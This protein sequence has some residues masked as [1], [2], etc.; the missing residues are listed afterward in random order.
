MSR[1]FWKFFIF[2]LV[3]QLTTVIGVGVAIWA[4]HQHETLPST[5]LEISPPAQS[6]IEAAAATLQ[7][8]G[9]KSLKLLLQSRQNRHMPQ[10]FVVDEHGQELMQRVYTKASF[11]SASK[12]AKITKFQRYAKY[13]K[14]ND[15]QIFLLF[16]PYIEHSDGDI[17]INLA[18]PVGEEHD[19]SL[20]HGAPLRFPL[21]PLIGGSL[22]SL[23]FAALLAW[24]FSK[25][26]NKL[27]AAFI[28]ASN[29]KLD[30]RVAHSMSG[31]RDELSDL[32][33]D[34]DAMASRLSSLLRG[35][36]R[37]LHHVSHELRSP[38]ARMQMALGLVKQ[39]PERMAEFLVRVELE[40]N[41]IDK[42]VDELLELSRLESG[43][44]Q[45]K[46]E[47]LDLNKLIHNIA[48]DAQ[49][50]AMEKNIKLQL[51]IDGK[52]ELEGHPELLYRAIEN[53]IRNAI[54]YGPDGGEVKVTC[55]HNYS[56]KSLHIIVS[57]QGAGVEESELEDIFKPFVR[58]HAGSQTTGHG[59][60]LAITKQVIDAHDGRVSA[61]N[62]KPNGFC[63][64]MVLPC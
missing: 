63:V 5:G 48:E 40:T 14:L 16:V 30:L 50:E 8:G 54:K 19:R 35:Q 9:I 37:L 31:R 49:F 1:L 15:R 38:L 13:I 55:F 29:G 62:L 27:R 4:Q 12:L 10:V 46:K 42:L 57:D 47:N 6:D 53:V 61:R 2:F 22:V 18:P 39:R 33:R 20:S 36:T 59:I 3:A 41:R 56:E 43:V 23:I 24:Y 45:V 26:I 17:H 25:P 60:G 34:F 64:E 28:Q 11:D 52:C 7:Y 21:A 51:E 58:G 32:G 44:I